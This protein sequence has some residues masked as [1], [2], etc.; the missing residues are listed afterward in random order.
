MSFRTYLVSQQL[1]KSAFKLS[2]AAEELRISVQKENNYF[3]SVMQLRKEWKITAPPQNVNRYQP[4]F[5]VDF[6]Y[7]HGKPPISIK[8]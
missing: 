3:D 8:P 7:F 2:Q 4:K 5:S 1:K 6:T